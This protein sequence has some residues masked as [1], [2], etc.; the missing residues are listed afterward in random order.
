M[1]VVLSIEAIHPPLA[2]IGR[3]AWELATRLPQFADV[4]QVRYMSDGFWCGLPPLESLRGGAPAAGSAGG[5]K[6]GLRRIAA[7]LPAASALYQRVRPMLA[8]RR[9]NQV[10]E[11]VFHGPNFFVPQSRIPSVVTIHDLSVYRH[12]DWHP[13]LRVE[14]MKRDVPQA[15][16]RAA[17]VI[18]D[19]EAVRQEVLQQFNL[20]PQKVHTV[21]VGV[22]EAYQPRS[23]QQTAAVL[24]QYGL[25]HDGYSLFVSTIEPRKNLENLLA[26]YRA[27]PPAERQQWPLVVAGGPG[28]LSDNI[29][30]QLQQ[31]HSEGWLHYLGFADQSHLPAL[32]AG[33]RLF[34]YPSWYEGFGIPLAEAMAS[35]VPVLTSNCS[36]MPEV[37][38]GAALLVTPADVRDITEN[39]RRG[40]QDEH[41]RAAAR[42]RGLAR[43]RELS[44][45]ACVRNTVN[46]YKAAYR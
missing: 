8:A 41:W 1:K 16:Q 17:A 43:A 37:A 36:S 46:V 14:R 3:Y 29:H 34:V 5:L 7:R 2:G 19:S 26:A 32:Y 21:W 27:L 12:A 44:W 38:A 42:E 24:Q 39:L 33:S 6:A 25:R 31:A 30:Q 4:E 35:G 13:R 22:D 9:L 18:T 11:G 45:D 23:A 15:L 20:P 40:L 10:R 28:W